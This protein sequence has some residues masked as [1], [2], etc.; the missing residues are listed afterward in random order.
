MSDSA[1]RLTLGDLANQVLSTASAEA[2]APLV[3]QL[4]RGTRGPEQVAAIA[5]RFLEAGPLGR[6]AFLEW[7]GR[8]RPQFV[9]P[10]LASLRP[11]LADR[12]IPSAMRVL[13]AARALRALPDSPE[14]VK[15]VA[16]AL[17]RGQSRWK[18]GLFARRGLS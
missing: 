8:I 13:A 7:A 14:A 17:T 9:E 1:P 5:E 11:L 4:A 3:A 2:R 16:R 18:M 15:P 10:V 12:K 6:R